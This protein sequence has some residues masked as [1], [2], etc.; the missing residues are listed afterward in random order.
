MR[1]GN[2]GNVNESLEWNFSYGTQQKLK[3]GEL[4]TL[5]SSELERQ[6][7]SENFSDC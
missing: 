5:M 7:I 3:A 1:N 4:L 6:G 2:G